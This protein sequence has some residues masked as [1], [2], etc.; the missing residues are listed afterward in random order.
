MNYF[1][2]GK[3]KPIKFSSQPKQYY[4]KVTNADGLSRNISA[5]T[6][7]EAVAKAIGLDGGKFTF[8]QYKKKKIK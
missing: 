5:E 6:E 4:F 1:K 3:L 8:Q 7:F 2:M